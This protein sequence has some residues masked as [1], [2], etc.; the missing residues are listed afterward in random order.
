[1]KKTL[2]ILT[3]IIGAFS[4]TGT[5]AQSSLQVFYKNSAINISGQTITVSGVLNGDIYQVVGTDTI[6]VV[7]SSGNVIKTRCQRNV[8]SSVAGSENSFCWGSG[9]YGATTN[10][11]PLNSSPD[12]AGGTTDNSFVGDY[13]PKNNA[14]ATTVKYLFYDNTNSND[15]VSVTVIYDVTATGVN[16]L[17]KAG[18]T[19]SNAYPNP[20]NSLVS[21]KYDLNE[22]SKSGKIVFY[23]MLGK[24][25][26]EIALTDKQGIAKINVSEFNAGIYFYTFIID[27]KEISTKKLVISS[28]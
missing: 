11:S 21:L 22:F 8:I 17:T 26:K 18:G 4:I 1:M 20:A 7:N 16:E 24:S 3:S 14:G 10:V 9:C 12:I 27:D 2:L 25:V 5:K 13:K 28:K 6:A 19:I 23:D 15:S